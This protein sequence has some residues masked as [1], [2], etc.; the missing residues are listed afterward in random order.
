VEE[1]ELHNRNGKEKMQKIWLLAIAIVVVLLIMSLPLV[2]E[3]RITVVT[4]LDVITNVSMDTPKIP[5]IV[6]L[7]PSSSVATGAYTINV[8]ASL[9]GILVFNS[10]I[11]NV[12]SGQYTFVWVKN[13]QPKAGTYLVNVQLLKAN[14]QVNSYGLY[15]TFR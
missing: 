15:V 10:T 7:I 8:N 12:P 4:S 9:N 13:G 14:S 3:T 1:G 2:Q 11:Q 5:L 6:W